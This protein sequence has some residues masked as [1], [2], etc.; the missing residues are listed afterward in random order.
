MPASMAGLPRRAGRM[1]IVGET[2][3]VARFARLRA[4]Q[5]AGGVCGEKGGKSPL[6]SPGSARLQPQPIK[7]TGARLS[8]L[9]LGGRIVAFRVIQSG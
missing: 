4:C 8:A 9:F 3:T 1:G 7:I 5:C 2:V 6:A